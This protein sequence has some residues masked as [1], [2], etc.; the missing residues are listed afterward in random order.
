MTWE[1]ELPDHESIIRA[2]LF[3]LGEYVFLAASSSDHFLV[4]SLWQ[5]VSYLCVR[6]KAQQVGTRHPFGQVTCQ[7]RNVHLDSN[8]TAHSTVERP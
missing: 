5:M 2:V 3:H 6:S 4:R 1:L 8:L 7:T